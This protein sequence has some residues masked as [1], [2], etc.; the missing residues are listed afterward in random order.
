MGELTSS[1]SGTF[2]EEYNG[3]SP[4]RKRGTRELINIQGSLPPGSRTTHPNGQEIQ[5]RGQGNYMDEQGT[6]DKAQT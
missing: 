3:N 1:S 2:L 6:P 5:Q 4:R